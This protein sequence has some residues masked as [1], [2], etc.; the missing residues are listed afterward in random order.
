MPKTQNQKE[1]CTCSKCIFNSVYDPETKTTQHGKYLAPRTIRTHQLQDRKPL[2]MEDSNSDKSSTNNS[3]VIHSDSSNGSVF[4]GPNMADNNLIY[5]EKEIQ[6]W[7]GE[8][9]NQDDFLIDVQNGT[10][11][12]TLFSKDQS[13]SLD[14]ALSLFVD[15][16]N[17]RG[18]KISGSVCFLLLKSPTLNSKQSIPYWSC[19][20]NSRSLFTQH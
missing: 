8:V 6:E 19:G 3:T 9:G 5:T 12:K 10:A 2:V 1:L 20:N 17:P 13:N 7:A 18:N 11:F 14:L 4:E 16:F 15:W